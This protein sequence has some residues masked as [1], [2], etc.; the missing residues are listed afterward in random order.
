[1]K[2]MIGTILLVGFL[3]LLASAQTN[4][5]SKGHGYVYVAPGVATEWENAKTVQV[6]AGGEWFFS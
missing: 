4:D 3:P 1:M 2:R 5:Y 6:G